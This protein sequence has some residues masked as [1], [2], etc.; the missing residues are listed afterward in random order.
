MDM[1]TERSSVLGDSR[2]V[3]TE[4]E[5]GCTVPDEGA[6]IVHA[7]DHGP[8]A[9]AGL[10]GATG[11]DARYAV[12]GDL[13]VAL[14]GL[15]IPDADVLLA[16]LAQHRAGEVVQLE[17]IAC[18]GFHK[19]VPVTLSATTE[20]REQAAEEEAAERPAWRAAE[21]EAAERRTRR[22]NEEL[23]K[24]EQRESAHEKQEI[25]ECGSTGC[26]PG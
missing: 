11:E 14:D 5:S 12:G 7:E 4:R 3:V 19:T 26:A 23:A 13:I 2:L 20:T 22:I 6:L 17:V 18:D 21:K 8:A 16:D 15:P 10:H 9:E 25:Q 24:A 1:T